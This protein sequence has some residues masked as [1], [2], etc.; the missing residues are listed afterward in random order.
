MRI[1]RLR[2]LL[3]RHL[4]ERN[5]SGTLNKSQGGENIHAAD[6]SAVVEG[7]LDAGG[8]EDIASPETSPEA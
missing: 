8:V 2:G 7:S 5:I 4:L 1:S 3:N 6:R